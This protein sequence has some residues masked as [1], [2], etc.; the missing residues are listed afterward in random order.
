MHD[1]YPNH[2]VVLSGAFVERAVEGSAFFS[3]SEDFKS[4]APPRNLSVLCG[5]M[6]FS[7]QEII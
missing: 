1:G 6:H 7:Q 2:D 3:L 5:E 4:T